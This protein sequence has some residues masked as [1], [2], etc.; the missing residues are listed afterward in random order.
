MSSFTRVR[1]QLVLLIVAAILV[2]GSAF[3]PLVAR[4]HAATDLGG[5]DLYTFCRVV[6][7]YYGQPSTAVL[8]PNYDAYGWRCRDYVGV[9]HSINTNAVCQWQYGYGAWAATNNPSSAYS[10][11]CYR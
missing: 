2:S 1:R 11:R 10:W 5:L 3:G 6:Q 7:V 9:L 8:V 4:T